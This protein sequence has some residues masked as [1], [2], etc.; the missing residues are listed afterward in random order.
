MKKYILSALVILFATA[1]STASFAQQHASSLE[2]GLTPAP[3]ETIESDAYSEKAFNLL[4]ENRNLLRGVDPSG[5]AASVQAP[6]QD[7]AEF[8]AENFSGIFS[9]GDDDEEESSKVEDAAFKCVKEIKKCRLTIQYKESEIIRE[10]KLDF[11]LNVEN[12]LPT[13]IVDNKVLILEVR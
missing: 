11:E 12:N 4:A 9:F 7:V 13:S 5:N 2:A 1:F 10:K 6:V 8:M 3:N